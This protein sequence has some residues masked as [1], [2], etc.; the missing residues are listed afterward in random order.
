MFAWLARLHGVFVVAAVVVVAAAAVVVAE[1]GVGEQHFLG[2]IAT[3]AA[4]AVE[5][6]R[7]VERLF[8]C[9]KRRRITGSAMQ[10]LA[11]SI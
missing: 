7:R 8:E 10:L 9:S 4:L 1:E 6:P 5:E 3:V 11:G 2:Q